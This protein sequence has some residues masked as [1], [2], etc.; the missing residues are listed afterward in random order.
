MVK[1]IEFNDGWF[2]SFY[3]EMCGHKEFTKPDICPQCGAKVLKEID[4]NN[5]LYNR[6][7]IEKTDWEKGY[8][9]GYEVAM[10]KYKRIVGQSKTNLKPGDE[11]IYEKEIKAVIMDMDEDAD[12]YWVFNENGV[13]EVLSLDDIDDIPKGHHYSYFDLLLK[14]LSDKNSI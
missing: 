5:K 11:I 6:N 2:T 4:L 3:C 7:L 9:K 1:Y 10:N 12:T 14:S 8:E 13:V